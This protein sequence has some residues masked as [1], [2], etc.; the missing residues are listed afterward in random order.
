MSAARTKSKASTTKQ[1][2]KESKPKVV[3]CRDCDNEIPDTDGISFRMSDHSFF[4]CCC[5]CGHH[6]DSYGRVSKLFRDHER[7]CTDYRQKNQKEQPK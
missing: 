5:V 4:L 2:D 7:T 6:I 3:R 1:T